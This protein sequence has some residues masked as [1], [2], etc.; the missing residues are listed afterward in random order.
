MILSRKQLRRDLGTLRL[1]ECTIGTTSVSLGAGATLSLVDAAL[2]ANPDYSGQELYVRAHVRVGSDDYRVG[3]YNPLSGG[4]YSAQTLRNAIASGA[5]FE[6][7][8]R[9]S[10][11]EL[12]ACLDQTIL[13]LR[14]QREVGIPSVD[15]AWFYTLDHA[16]S[17]NT[18]I[19]YREVYYFAQP[20][21]S[22][23]RQRIDLPTARVVTTATGTELRLGQ[24]LAASVQLV[25]DAYLQLSLPASDDATINIP[26][27]D[28]VL[29]GA[30]ARAYD[31]MIQNAPGQEE[32]HLMQRRA[33]AARAFSRI[34]QRKQP[35]IDHKLTFEAPPAGI[36]GRNSL[37]GI[38][39]F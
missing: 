26:D 19:D 9:L 35:S 13:D 33:E 31:L 27:R 25:I 24:S 29:W 32:T 10:A 4:L 3:S 5:D 14:V 34:S 17:P 15:G 6:I 7:H 2:L 37:L 38:D 16:A 23:N 8:E 28:W 36:G 30:A 1:K 39:P 11:A 12:D 20:D 18:I 22:L 21:G